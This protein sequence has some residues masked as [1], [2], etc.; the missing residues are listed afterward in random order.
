VDR[1][2]P[3]DV[4]VDFIPPAEQ[5]GVGVVEA[6]ITLI[7]ATMG[8]GGDYCLREGEQQNKNKRLPSVKVRLPLFEHILGIQNRPTTF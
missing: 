3:R 8:G 2:L 5:L 1:V 4:R 7:N 6:R